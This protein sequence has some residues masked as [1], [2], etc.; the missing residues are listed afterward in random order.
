MSTFWVGMKRRCRASGMA[1]ALLVVSLRAQAG[2]ADAFYVSGES[3]LIGGAIVSTSSSG[4]SI[5]YNPSGLARMTGT[6]LDVNVSGYAVRFGA[7]A[8]FE[9]VVP[10]TEA[11]KLSLLAF[12]VVPAAFTLTRRVGDFGVGLGV[13]VPSQRAVTLR[14]KLDAPPDANGNSLVFGYDSTSRFQE[15]HAGPG[16][17]FSP[18]R[19]LNLGLSLLANY[20]TRVESTQVSATVES[21]S[22]KTSWFRHNSLDSQGVGLELVL[23]SQ[24]RFLREWSW[25]FV[26]RTPAIRLGEAV[27][28]VRSEF[29]AEAEGTVEDSVEFER[30]FGVSTQVLTPFRFH[31]G[32]SRTV[33]ETTGSIEGSV[34]LPFENELFDINERFTWNARAGMVTRL[35]DFWKFGGGVF[36]DRSSAEEPTQFQQTQ[37]DYYGATVSVDWMRSYGVVSKG[38]QAFDEPRTLLFGTTLA[39]S[40]AIGV[41]KI[42]GARVGPTSDGDI[43]FQRNIVDVLAHEITFHIGSTIAE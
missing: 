37:I 38:R 34:L 1:F 23:G 3:A 13:F 9:S 8:D 28:S 25:G 19:D 6:R 4:G 32:V 29:L 21:E 2:N 14:T 18:L 42:A 22:T 40:Y 36:T 5:W 35:S 10:N 15:Y 20:R 33:G 30:R 7:T 26:V 27:H 12:D 39:L 41:G 31:T 24:L 43:V 17:G 11:T 16:I